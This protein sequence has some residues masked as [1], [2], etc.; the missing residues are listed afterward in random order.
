MARVVVVNDDPDI[1]NLVQT[2]LRQRGHK[3]V[4]VASGSDALQALA[5]RGAPDV[6]VLDVSM[7]E[8]TG[9]ELLQ[10]LRRREGLQDLPAVFLSARVL[11]DDIEA[12][13]RLGAT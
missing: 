5:E 3:V 7:P 11:P 1:L 13:R 6:A 10:E 12:G 4:A 8:M 2:R 9:L